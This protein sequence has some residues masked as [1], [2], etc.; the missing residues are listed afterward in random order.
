MNQKKQDDYWKRIFM[1]QDYIEQY[2]EK[3]FTYEQLVKVS[4][5]SKYHFHRIFKD[6]TKETIFQ[7]MTRVKMEKALQYLNHRPNLSITDIAFTLG[8]S[9]A[10]VFSRSFKR[11]Y[12][13]APREMKNRN[14][15]KEI[16]ALTCYNE[17][18]EDSHYVVGEA[19]VINQAAMT[20]IYYRS[21]GLLTAPGFYANVLTSLYRYA[22]A[23]NLLFNETKVLSI[24]HHHP[25]YLHEHQQ[26]TSICLS[27]IP[28]KYVDDLS[29]GIMEIPGGMYGVM[30]FNI[31]QNDY[32]K[33][34]RYVYQVWLPKSG[35][36]TRDAFPFEVYLNNP[37][38]DA[39]GMH[40]VEIYVPIEPI[41]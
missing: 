33:A 22:Q 11:Y 40:Q 7:Y 29:Y 1:V 36:Q 15:C 9:D 21:I 25:D 20:V 24:Y 39:H 28:I 17:E 10:A 30:N 12:Q 32:A 14:N 19:R 4:G 37:S 34:W 16:E 2:P 38:D 31:H 18:V 41:K 8:F 6:L 26:R 23:Q 27:I 5:I 3:N 35:Y 13:F